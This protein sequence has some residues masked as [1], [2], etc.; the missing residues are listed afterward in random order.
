MFSNENNKMKELIQQ[1]Y[2]NQ[3][4]REPT[5]FT[6]HSSSLIDLILVRNT[7]GNI[8]SG[9][10]DSFIPDQIRFHCHVLVL[11]KF[12]RPTVKRIKDGYGIIRLLILINIENS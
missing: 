3:L 4:I 7:T 9:V 8:T 1:Y 2:L 10:A 12:L 5:H 11:L 6:E